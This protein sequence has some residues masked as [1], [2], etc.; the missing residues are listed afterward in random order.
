MADAVTLAY[1]AGVVDSDGTI[2][3]HR[4]ARG[5]REYFAARIG[6]AG[7]RREPH[8]LA[9]SIWGGKVGR[10]EPKDS[11]HRVYYQWSRTGDPAVEPICSI[12]PY[13]RVKRDQAMLALELQEHVVAGR[14]DSPYPWQLPE[15]DPSPHSRDLRAEVVEVLNQDRRAAGRKQNG[16]RTPKAG[17]R[18]LD[19]RTWDEMPEHAGAVA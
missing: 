14:G 5:G 1:L 18:E 13:L 12:L 17:G 19:G 4:S 2:T 8:D 3:I 11:R 16:G 15:Y 9:S 10:Y 6:I 7:T